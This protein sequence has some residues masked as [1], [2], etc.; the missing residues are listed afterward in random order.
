[1]AERRGEDGRL[2]R[3]M[4]RALDSGNA[5]ALDKAFEAIYRTYVRSVALV[6]ARFLR[7]DA[8]VQSVTND[9]FVAF[10]RRMEFFD[11]NEIVSLRA[12]LTAAAR[13]AALNHLRAQSKRE[14]ALVDICI[15]E[16]DFDGDADLLS[17]LP[18]PDGDVTVSVRYAEL[19]TDLRRTVGDEAAEIILL[20]A[21]CGESFPVISA[22]LGRKENTV[23]TMYHRAIQKFRREKGDRWQ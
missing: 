15:P 19:I 11:E 10:F 3:E 20:H 13:H 6:C 16:G 7:D 23:K 12:Y 18:D 21:V 9:V 2:L 1:M 17:M 22:R 8:D 14:G 4:S 5:A